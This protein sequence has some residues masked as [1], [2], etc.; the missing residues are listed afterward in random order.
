MFD[1]IR[2][3]FRPRVNE[4]PTMITTES[5]IDDVK[6]RRVAIEKY[7]IKSHE[8]RTKAKERLALFPLN[9]PVD[10]MEITLSCKIDWILL[11]TI[12]NQMIKEGTWEFVDE[13]NRRG[14]GRRVQRVK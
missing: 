10:E 6:R 5:I 14:K 12:I 1:W 13:T 8:N 2:K 11:L 9:Y 3:R 4:E 7:R